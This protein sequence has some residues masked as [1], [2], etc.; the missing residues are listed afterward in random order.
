MER[1]KSAGRKLAAIITREMAESKLR[2]R[3]Q[4][5]VAQGRLQQE[6]R[7]STNGQ[8]YILRKGEKL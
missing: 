1:G 7:R 6:R 4:Y 8:V 2:Y 3:T 5:L